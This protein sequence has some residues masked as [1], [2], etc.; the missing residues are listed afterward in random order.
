VAVYAKRASAAQ[1]IAVS[2]QCLGQ[3]SR[4]EAALRMSVPESLQRFQTGLARS[5]VQHRL[6]DWGRERGGGPRT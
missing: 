1:E 3:G 2:G 4:A 5:A 6:D